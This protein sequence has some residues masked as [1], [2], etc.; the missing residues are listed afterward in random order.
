MWLCLFVC[1]ECDFVCLCDRNV[2]LLVCLTGMWLCLFR[3]QKCDFV[4]LCVRNVT[5]LVCVSGMWLF[6]CVSGMWLCSFVCQECDFVRL[7]MCQ[8][9]DCSGDLSSW[10]LFAHRHP[11]QVKTFK[12]SKFY[13]T[14]ETVFFNCR[15]KMWNLIFCD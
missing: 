1:Q 10:T 4:S 11:H 8:E 6:V 7:F 3:C 9:C 5:L 12:T 14:P 13:L 15:I 2:T